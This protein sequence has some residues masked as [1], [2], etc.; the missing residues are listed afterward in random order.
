MWIAV[1]ILEV[2]VNYSGLL[3]LYHK[4]K[5]TAGFVMNLCDTDQNTVSPMQ[6]EFYGQQEVMVDYQV[7]TKIL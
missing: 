7:L 3:A 2:D 5:Y 4:Y 1:L 6:K